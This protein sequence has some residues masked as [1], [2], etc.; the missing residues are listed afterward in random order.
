M[1]KILYNTCIISLLFL[2][3]LQTSPATGFLPPKARAWLT[4]RNALIAGGIT[5]A[6]LFAAWYKPWQW[7]LFGNGSITN[8]SAVQGHAKQQAAVLARYKQQHTDAAVARHLNN[9]ELAAVE[10]DQ[11]LEDAYGHSARSLRDNNRPHPSAVAG[12]AAA[13]AVA[14]PAHP[15]VTRPTMT[16]GTAA[17]TTSSTTSYHGGAAQP[18]V[19]A[20]ATPSTRLD[21]LTCSDPRA[22]ALFANTGLRV[23]R[24]S[25]SGSAS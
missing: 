13:S 24:P 1:K 21:A 11:R 23:V 9:Q 3:T 25:T 18:V 7:N 19:A 17:C 22:L 10:H 8:G 6:A 15:L 2:T 12:A 16:N 20:A 5:L 4:Q 14:S